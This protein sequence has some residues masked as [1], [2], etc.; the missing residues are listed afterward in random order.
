M[1]L[2]DFESADWNLTDESGLVALSSATYSASSNLLNHHN[3][4]LYRDYGVGGITGDCEFQLR[5]YNNGNGGWYTLPCYVFGFTNSDTILTAN[6][7][8]DIPIGV[9][10]RAVTSPNPHLTVNGGGGAASSVQLS[11]WVN[12]YLTIII[13][14]TAS[15]ITVRIYSDAARTQLLDTIASTITDPISHRW[16]VALASY[17]N[18]NAD[19]TKAH[20]PVGGDLEIVSMGAAAASSNSESPG[21]RMYGPRHIVRPAAMPTCQP[22]RFP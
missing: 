15:S 22:V 1:A 2:E 20:R 11:R 21:L 13:D 12:Y 5:A 18:G 9:W 6:T 14:D 4:A 3:V 16:L 19:G 17:D 7:T 10:W 8:N